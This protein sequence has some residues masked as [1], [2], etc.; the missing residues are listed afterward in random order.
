MLRKII[1]LSKTSD[2]QNS[3]AVGTG[4]KRE[5]YVECR[6][7][8]TL[9][10]T[11]GANGKGVGGGVRAGLTSLLLSRGNPP[12]AVVALYRMGDSC[13]LGTSRASGA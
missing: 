8:R 9:S 4:D 13:P 11:D 3:Q 2:V 10:G 6:L 7:L 12:S 1:K 5:A